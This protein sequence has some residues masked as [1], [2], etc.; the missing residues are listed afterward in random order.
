ML[1]PPD[2]VCSHHRGFHPLKIM[3]KSHASIR[4][5][6]GNASGHGQ[7]KSPLRERAESNSCEEVEETDAL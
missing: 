2:E 6:H 5:I 3:V 4:N 1:M 7:K